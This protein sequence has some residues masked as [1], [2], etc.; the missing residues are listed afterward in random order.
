[1]EREKDGWRRAWGRGSLIKARGERG[2]TCSETMLGRWTTWGGSEPSRA[3]H[4]DTPSSPNPS[5]VRSPNTTDPAL[6][7]Y[8]LPFN[9]LS[10]PIMSQSPI[11]PRHRILAPI[12]ASPTAASES[13]TPRA[14][15]TPTHCPRARTK[16][17]ASAHRLKVAEHVAGEHRVRW[18]DRTGFVAGEALVLA[19]AAPSRPRASARPQIESA[20]FLGPLPPAP[21]HISSPGHCCI[22]SAGPPAKARVLRRAFKPMNSYHMCGEDQRCDDAIVSTGLLPLWLGCDHASPAESALT[23]RSCF[24]SARYQ[25]SSF[26]HKPHRLPAPTCGP[27]CCLDA[28]RHPDAPSTSRLGAFCSREPLSTPPATSAPVQTR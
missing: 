18:S 3:F 19:P 23:C 7:I 11:D 24:P 27:S 5:P 13:S 10:N 28:L 14:C 4:A 16:E 17:K 15:P 1:M 21:V 8:I 26:R 2:S 20:P 25:A 6:P 9:K 22:Q 12:D